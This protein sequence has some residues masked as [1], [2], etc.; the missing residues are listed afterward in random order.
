M[1]EKVIHASVLYNIYEL[2]R[3]CLRYLLHPEAQWERIRKKTM[4]EMSEKFAA[5]KSQCSGCRVQLQETSTDNE[6]KE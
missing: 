3:T 5:R 2:S 1:P 4:K 6:G